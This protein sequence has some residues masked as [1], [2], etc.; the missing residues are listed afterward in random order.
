MSL[1]ST[2][3]EDSSDNDSDACFAKAGRKIIPFRRQ[4]FAFLLAACRTAN[5][6]SNKAL[7]WT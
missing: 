2:L 4:E 6:T 7:L 3:D 5:I 1:F